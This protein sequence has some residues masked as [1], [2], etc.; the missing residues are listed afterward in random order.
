MWPRRRRRQTPGEAVDSVELHMQLHRDLVAQARSSE[1]AFKR[2]FDLEF[3]QQR[4]DARDRVELNRQFYG[5]FTPFPSTVWDNQDMKT[6]INLSTEN[7]LRADRALR[8]SLGREPT[9]TEVAHFLENENSEFIQV[10]ITGTRYT[11]YSPGTEVGDFVVVPP[12][13][14]TPGRPHLKQVVAKGNGAPNG[15][16]ILPAHKIPS[17]T[18]DRAQA[19][20]AARR[21]TGDGGV[22]A[23]FHTTRPSWLDGDEEF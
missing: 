15:I 13:P 12:Y 17:W 22:R 19:T 10:D 16:N 23:R 18:T 20:M 1:G 14:S 4:Q 8:R 5:G 11:Y 6:S 21:S 3:D 9:V 7:V 2:A